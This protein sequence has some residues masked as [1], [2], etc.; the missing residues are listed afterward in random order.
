VSQRIGRDV[1]SEQVA[2]PQTVLQDQNRRLW[3]GGDFE[4]RC[5]GRHANQFLWMAQTGFE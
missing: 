2:A 4:I 1:P 3:I 5:C